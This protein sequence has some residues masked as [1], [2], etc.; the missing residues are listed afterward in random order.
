MIQKVIF[1]KRIRCV[2]KGWD[3]GQIPISTDN[4]LKKI[5]KI[6][7]NFFPY[8]NIKF[9]AALLKHINNIYPKA[10][11]VINFYYLTF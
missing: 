2:A 3:W 7:P 10:L 4:I 11:S 1:N 5:L 6:L 8:K 9:L